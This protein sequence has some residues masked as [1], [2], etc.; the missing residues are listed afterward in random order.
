[1]IPVDRKAPKAE[2]RSRLRIHD[3][4]EDGAGVLR[5]FVRAYGRAIGKFEKSA[6]LAHAGQ[7]KPW[8]VKLY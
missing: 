2:F 3:I 7:L 1:M 6:D 8:L 4:P 5:P